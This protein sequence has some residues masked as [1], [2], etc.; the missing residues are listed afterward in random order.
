MKKIFTALACAIALGFSSVAMAQRYIVITHTDGTDP[1]WPVVKRGAEDA[2]KAMGVEMEYRH[3]SAFDMVEMARIIEAAT[4]QNPAGIIVSLPDPDGLGDAVKAAVA[5]GVPVISINSGGDIA[6]D[7]GVLLHVG[8]PEYEA[9]LGAGKKH[10]SMGVTKVV[11]L[12][13]EA[14]NAALEQRCA[15]YQDGTGVPAQLLDTTSD[16]SKIKSVTSAAVSSDPDIDGIL[17]LG[18]HVC[19]AAVEALKE[20]GKEGTIRL[21]CFDLTPGVIED[22]QAGYVDFAIDQQ[23]YL[24]GYLPIVALVLYNKYGLVPGGDILSGPGF[25]TIDNAAA[26]KEFAGITR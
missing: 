26:V 13:Q 16:P 5:A 15:G 18:P 17:A 3:P 4:A 10:K 11:C 8:Q 23:Q 24:Q 9:G 20:L 21:G 2:A 6:A 19:E 25:V 7:L 14:T 12:S 1:F 22:I